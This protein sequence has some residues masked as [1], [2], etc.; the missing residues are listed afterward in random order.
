MPVAER[1][2]TVI[3]RFGRW[4]ETVWPGLALAGGIAAVAW[5]VGQAEQAIFTYAVVEPVVLALLLGMGMRSIQV[6]PAVTMAGVAFAAK[7]VL[8]GAIV[9]LGASLDLATVIDAG[10]KLAG[11]VL[12]SVVA[13]IVFGAW[14]GWRAG[15]TPKLALLIAVGNAIC[16]NS[17]IAALAPTIRAKKQEV[18]SAIALTAV[19]GVGVVLSLPLLIP[20]AG[21]N[22]YQYG[23][24]AGLT[25]YAVPQV[26]AATFPVSA[27]SGQIGTLV[28]LTRVLL[29]GP[30]VALFA[31]MYRHEGGAK[32]GFSVQRFLPWFV[33]G[34][35]VMALARTGGLVPNDLGGLA[36]DV[37]RL[38][39]IVA[40][41]A[42][43]LGVDFRV[44]RTVGL[45]VALVVVGLL[46]VMVVLALALIGGLGLDS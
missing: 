38:L 9:L 7:G 45:R 24:L 28:K 32:P 16:G 4:S 42:L 1:A 2:P 5:L 3:T 15:L 8:E 25:V 43:G 35:L 23:V 21:L 40:M 33:V 18:A 12:V 26:L 34:F 37:S 31:F 36:K 13:T 44:V 22:D 17:A 10:A 19:L 46:V 14:L 20:L 30:V 27:E 6:P 41:A 11:A 39:T 29:L